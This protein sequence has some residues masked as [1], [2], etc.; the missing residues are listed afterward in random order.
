MPELTVTA[1]PKRPKARKAPTPQSAPA[2]QTQEPSEEEP[3]QS[4]Y[5]SSALLGQAR[6]GSEGV[7][8]RSEL[9]SQPIYRTGELLE[10]TPGLIVT[11]HSG[12]GKANQYFLR[13]FNLDH[14]TDLAITV[15]GMPVNMR[16]HGHGQGYADTGFLIP[17]IM[18][19]LLYR[20]G[21]Y[22]AAEGDFASAGAIHLDI[23]D[24]LEKNFAQV[25]L[26]SF[27]HRR[28]V[29][30]M[31]APV[32]NGGNMLVA[33]EV[34]RFDGPWERPDD[35]RKL[36]GVMRYSR[37]S[38]DNGFAIT[39][40]AYSGK[41][42]ATD[43]I[44]RRAVDSGLIG[45]YGNIDSTDGGEAERFSLS[46]RWSERTADTLTRA[47]AYAIKSDLALFNNFTYLLSN[48]VDGD[49]FKQ[50]DHRWIG[51]AGASRTFFGTAFA[52]VKSETTLGVQS[53]YD[54]IKVGL[55]NTRERAVLSTV[56]EDQAREFSVGI[57]GESTLRWTPWLR[58]TA[59]LRGDLFSADVSSNLGANSGSEIDAIL[60]PKAGIVLGPWSK[61]EFYLNA[62]TGFHSN[63]ARGTV[64]TVDP[65]SLASAQAVPFLVRSKGAEIGLRS[66][67]TKAMQS[68]LA[69]FI[70]D[71][72]SEIVFV[73]DAG[74]TEASRPSRRIGLEYTL[75]SKLLPWLTLDL[76]AA[77]TRARFLEDDPG[78]PGRYIPGAT[79]GVVSASLSFENLMGGWFGGVR[80]RYFGPRPLIEDNSVRSNAS[81]PV[82]ARLGYKFDDGLIVRVDGFN[83]L[84]QKASQIDY[85]YASRLM[86]EAAAGVNDS[87]FHPLEP[88]SFRLSLTKQF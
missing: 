78:A 11:Q 20:K 81:M 88:R 31:S 6:S 56:R 25:E 73:G 27:G 69:A 13:G 68:T 71:F 18:R 85:Y 12:E 77:Y 76:D 15:D 58:T 83:L 53:R 4:P 86:G 14:G 32:G 84:D 37:G 61:T 52:G 64:I 55:Y 66:E 65:V 16:T 3:D 24:R 22:F 62:G 7:A 79:E 49:Q 19:G 2:P 60:S 33:G 67:P 51:G 42:Y 9:L 17:E 82:S 54:D 74:T 36:N 40:M 26:G 87:H 34:V 80:V 57:F 44:P 48:P 5:S 10:A 1:P 46:S 8:P 47:S 63:D 21:P 43:Q 28:A 38:Y 39:G 45:R 70:L 23:V 59:G 50:T 72:D 75:R 29:A 35:L 41:W 30:G